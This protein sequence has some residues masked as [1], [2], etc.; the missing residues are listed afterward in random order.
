MSEFSVI[1]RFMTKLCCETTKRFGN[2]FLEINLEADWAF[3]ETTAEF[4]ISYDM[5][6]CGHS[7]Y[8]PLVKFALNRA[9]LTDETYRSTVTKQIN[10]ELEKYI[11]ATH[12][13]YTTVM[14]D[15]YLYIRDHYE[16]NKS[17]KT[18]HPTSD[19]EQ[20]L[21]HEVVYL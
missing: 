13:K 19:P 5:D 21:C 1:G 15:Y 18:T 9:K 10:V 8:E 11:K 3:D 17:G 4:W 6:E 14:A 7:D 16:E 2:I 12:Y 20:F